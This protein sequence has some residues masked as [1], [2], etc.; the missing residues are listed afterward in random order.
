MGAVDVGTR[1]AELLGAAGFPTNH[2]PERGFDH[3]VFIPLKLAY[4]EAE[5]PTVQV[6]VVGVPAMT[7]FV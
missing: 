5:I 6:G 2:D 4:P 1:T 7:P 3:G